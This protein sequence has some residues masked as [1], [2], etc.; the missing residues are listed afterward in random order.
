MIGC[1]NPECKV[2]IHE[3]CLIE[4]ACQ[5]KFNEEHKD[6]Q[7]K[8]KGPRKSSGK[9]PEL[10]RKHYKAELEKTELEA[11]NT[12]F[13]MHITRLEKDGSALPSSQ[14]WTEDIHC[15]KCN[16]LID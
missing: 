10:W 4:D 16:H 14:T 5:R 15:L 3:E 2:W 8:K 12:K 7:Q 6:D 11:E 9:R 1:P 13:K